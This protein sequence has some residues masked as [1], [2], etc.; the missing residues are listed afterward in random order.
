MNAR[1]RLFAAVAAAVALAVTAAPLE[2]K[3]RPKRPERPQAERRVVRD[4]PYSNRA[5]RREREV[6]RIV[7]KIERDRKPGYYEFGD[8]DREETGGDD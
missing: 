1:Y 7:R 3:E 6:L 4:T 2:A 8:V 5:V